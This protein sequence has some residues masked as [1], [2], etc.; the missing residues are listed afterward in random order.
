M[1]LFTGGRG[2]VI[3]QFDLAAAVG[4]TLEVRLLMSYVLPFNLE[5]KPIQDYFKIGARC[6]SGFL[7]KIILCI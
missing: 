7:A 6:L 1:M 5:T 3:A 4:N 2:V